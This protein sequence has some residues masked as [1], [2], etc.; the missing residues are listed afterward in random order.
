MELS[1][2]PDDIIAGEKGGGSRNVIRIMSTPMM[3]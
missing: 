1:I 2:S 3:T